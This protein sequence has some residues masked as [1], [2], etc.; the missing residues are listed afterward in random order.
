MAPRGLGSFIAMPIVGAVLGRFDARKMLS[1][2]IIGASFTLLQLSWLN[3][4]A[5]YWQIF[6]PQLLQGI[7]LSLLFVPLTTVTMDSITKEQMGNATSIFNLMRN[8]GGS[9]GIA[10]AT[11]YLERRS[12]L[13]INVLGR[14]V[15]LY[16]AQSRQMIDGMRGALMA[17]GADAA[18]ATQQA[19]GAIFGMV[20]RQASTLSFLD[21]FRAMAVVFLLLL[22][23]LLIMR[24]PTHRGG[25]A[26]TH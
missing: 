4:D 11:T 3:L 24:R 15:D 6:W 19:H 17:R 14:H 26:A 16:G 22:P 9:M 1:F 10:F 25:A 23:L 5:G 12:Q 2:G 8:I 13:H 7:A 20:Q 18:T 21:T